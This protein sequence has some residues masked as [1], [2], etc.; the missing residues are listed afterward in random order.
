M[1]AR[2]EVLRY[3][4][5]LKYFSDLN[6]TMQ[7]NVKTRPVINGCL[8][9]QTGTTRLTLQMIFLAENVIACCVCGVK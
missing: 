1:I 6:A 2:S 7:L 9:L 5:F 4:E 8:L 3:F